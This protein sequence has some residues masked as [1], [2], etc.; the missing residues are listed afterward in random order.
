MTEEKFT[1]LVNLYLDQEISAEDLELLKE[2]LSSKP[3]RQHA[4]EERVRIEKAMRMAFGCT[5]EVD[6]EGLCNPTVSTPET[7]VIRF[8]RW[9]IGSSLAASLLL[10][11]VLIPQAIQKST[12]ESQASLAATESVNADPLDRVGKSEYQRYAAAKEENFFP[13]ASL[14]SHMRLLGLRPEHTPVEKELLPVRLSELQV[15]SQTKS[16]AQLLRDIQKLRPFPE[17]QVLVEDIA[18]RHTGTSF[19]NGFSASLVR[20]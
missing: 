6:T 4:L 18:P 11:A 7:K 12:S 19:G 9:A 2:E 20:Y 3:E 16:R 15:D 17:T 14:A 13:H 8:P 10:A 1:E 5:R